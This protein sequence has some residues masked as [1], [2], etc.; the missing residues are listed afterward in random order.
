MML[1]SHPA[2]CLPKSTTDTEFFNRNY[3]DDLKDLKKHF[4]HR[5]PDQITGEFT[6]AYMDDPLV[7]RRI[8]RH[9][10]EAKFIFGYRESSERIAS[11]YKHY[12]RYGEI[13]SRTFTEACNEMPSIMDAGRYKGNMS[14]WFDCF[15]KTNFLIYDFHRIGIDPQKL[16]EEICTFLGISPLVFR[17]VAKVFNAS[18]TPRFPR[19]AGCVRSNVVLLRR[20]GLF[21]LVKLGKLMGL[22]LLA[23]SGGKN[24]VGLAA[25]DREF[26][27]REFHDDDEFARSLLRNRAIF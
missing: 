17:D 6:A 18:T 9:F 19:V 20:Y 23:Y 21:H 25:S 7:P 14:R 4:K 11:L 15:P 16:L 27:I 1:K 3:R 26:I 12:F 8:A 22:D 13:R 2:I 10:P 5:A 24:P